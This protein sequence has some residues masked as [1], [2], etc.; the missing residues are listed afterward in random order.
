MILEQMLVNKQLK[1]VGNLGDILKHGA[2]VRLANLVRARAIKAPVI[3]VETHS[4]LL[5]AP[6][7]EQLKWKQAVNRQLAEHPYY[8][9]YVRIEAE[10][11]ERGEPY[12]CSAGLVLDILRGAPKQVY[13]AEHDPDT[14]ARLKQQL[15]A[16]HIRNTTVV[17]RAEA[18]RDFSIPGGEGYDFEPEEVSL[19]AL[20]DPFE[21]EE[22]EWKQAAEQ[23]ARFADKAGCGIILAFDYQREVDAPEWPKPPKNFIGPVATISRAPYHLAAY[24]TEMMREEIQRTLGFLGWQAR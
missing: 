9:D 14:R 12:R 7:N 23:A 2:L 10:R 24:T 18:L 17:E 6:W 20:V 8:K 19:L 5:H 16:E 22:S 21:L 3:Y 13:L 11:L 15:E 1:N 4:F